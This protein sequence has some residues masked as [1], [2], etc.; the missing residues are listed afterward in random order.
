MH[1]STEPSVDGKP[2]LLVIDDDPALCLLMEQMLGAA[3]WI[4]RS[5]RDGLTGCEIFAREHFDLVLLDVVMPK[6]DGFTICR[7]LRATSRREDIPIVIITGRDDFM[8]IESAYHAGATDFVTKPV[9]WTLL[10]HRLK[11]ILRATRAFSALR[12]SEAH[13]SIAQEIARLGSWEWEPSTDTVSMSIQASRIFG[14]QEAKKI[15]G[16]ARLF[17]NVQARDYERVVRRFTEAW[18]ERRPLTVDCRVVEGHCTRAI[19]LRAEW[20]PDG[21]LGDSILAGTVQ[22]VTS[23]LEAAEQIQRLAYYDAL[24]G[25]ANR[26]SLKE[27]LNEALEA[28]TGEGG[29]CIV[30]FIGIDNFKLINETYGHEIGNAVLLQL[31]QR[32]QHSLKNW[33]MA[34]GGPTGAAMPL[35]A[36]VGG[37][38]FAVLLPHADDRNRVA[39]LAKALRD[40]SRDVFQFSHVDAI[41]SVSIGISTYPNDANS[42]AEMLKTADLARYEAKRLG[43]NSYQFYRSTIH[44]RSK[45]HTIV[46]RELRRAYEEGRLELY[47]QPR[48]RLDTGKISGVE[49]LL[50]WNSEHLGAVDPCEFIPIAEATGLIIPIG[51]WVLATALQQARLWQRNPATDPLRL[52]V[53]ISPCQFKHPNFLQSLKHNLSSEDWTDRLELEITETV[54]L[55]DS[56]AVRVTMDAVKEMGIRIVV[57]DFGAGYASVNNL[58]RLPIDVLKIDRSFIGGLP[59]GARDAAITSAIIDLTRSLQLGVV[60][61]GVENIEQLDFLKARC[62]T[63]IQGY[64]FSEAVPAVLIDRMIAMHHGAL[65]II[66][67]RS[68]S[69]P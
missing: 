30:L 26:L 41:L 35:V 63:E 52:A 18:T 37:E 61:E 29:Q 25:L 9:N 58:K 64:L 43:R 12:K 42:A 44:S 15:T 60:A 56:P 36:R 22:D 46:Q 27:R 39:D 3:G 33:S 34:L 32:F 50:R 68:P 55:D 40:V 65:P 69:A 47:Y 51:E 66:F 38:E 2:R 21:N 7:S 28:C 53:N 23:Q 45:R 48:V 17:A 67:G 57:D 62:C 54:L 49:A 4:V 59:H 16:Y 5:A 13:L 6:V 20:I 10:P 14:F 11:Y 24:T 8:S 19:A 1:Y 31:A